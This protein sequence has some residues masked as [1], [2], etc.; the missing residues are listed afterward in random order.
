MSTHDD[1]RTVVTDYY[2]TNI[3]LISIHIYDVAPI[4]PIDKI[5]KAKVLKKKKD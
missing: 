2:S 5:F 1:H 3:T 4:V